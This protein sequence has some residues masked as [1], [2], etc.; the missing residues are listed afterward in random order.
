MRSTIYVSVVAMTLLFSQCQ[1]PTS[2]KPVTATTTG[3]SAVEAV[4]S[5][6]SSAKVVYVDLDSLQDKYAWFKETKVQFEQRER[7]LSSSI[8]NKAQDLQ[9]QMSA[10]NEKAQKG[11]T[12]PAQLQQEGQSLQRRQQE[13]VGERDKKSKELLDE[14][15]QFNATLQK[16]VA[17]V[18]T[19]L[20][21]QKGYDYVMSYSKAGGGTILYVN[22]KLDVTAEVLTLLNALPK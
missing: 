12:P 17:T 18:L 22:P 15:Q 20:Q 1:N 3:A 14:S 11:T 16:R 8:E 21:Q 5:G 10:L 19:Q 2:T 13:L 6:L 9:R 7:A 4:A